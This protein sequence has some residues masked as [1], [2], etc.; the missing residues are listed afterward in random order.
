MALYVTSI[1]YSESHHNKTTSH[2]GE[3]IFDLLLYLFYPILEVS[4]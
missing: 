1:S 3:C 2:S 4:R